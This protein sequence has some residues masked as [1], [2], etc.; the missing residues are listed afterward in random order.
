MLAHHPSTAGTVQGFEVLVLAQPI[1]SFHL[2]TLINTLASSIRACA[3]PAGR[4]KKLF[5]IFLR[6]TSQQRRREM[7][8]LWNSLRLG[9]DVLNAFFKSS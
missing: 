2:V 3:T 6:W 8:T 9:A 7:R 1:L 5:W 4:A